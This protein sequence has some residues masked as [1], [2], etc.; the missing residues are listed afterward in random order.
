[1][2][3]DMYS[4]HAMHIY[5]IYNY[6]I[7]IYIYTPLSLQLQKIYKLKE[8][9]SRLDCN[10]TGTKKRLIVTRTPKSCYTMPE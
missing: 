4:I 6:Y 7:Y 9:S 10:L 3:T 5:N 1:M 2:P 8:G